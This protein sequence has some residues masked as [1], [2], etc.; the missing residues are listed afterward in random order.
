MTFRLPRAALKKGGLL[1]ALGPDGELRLPAEI[2][3]LDAQDVE[4]LRMRRAYTERMPISSRLPITYQIVPPWLRSVIA[5]AVGRWMRRSVGR[6]AAFPMWPI[7]LSADFLEDLAGCSPSPF[8][9][10][11]TPVVLTHDLDSPEGLRN[12][13]SHFLAEEEEVGARSASFVVPNGW[14]LEH[15]L[16]DEV[17][18]RGHEIG[19]H[20]YDHSNLTPYLSPEARRSRLR[21]AL[22]LIERYGVLGYRAPS[23]VRTRELLRDLGAYYRYDTSIPTSG[24]LFPVPNNGCASARLFRAEGIVEIPV[25][26]PRDGSL[27]FLGH[28]PE[29]IYCT[30]VHC[31]EQISR[32]GGVVV[33]L[34]HCEERFSGNP[35]MLDVYRRLL[36]YLAESGRFTWSTP[37]HVM[38]AFLQS[39]PTTPRECAA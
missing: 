38:D 32:S 10:G 9:A 23:L 33:L 3:Q 28:T 13:V 30:W 15:D 24:G 17:A 39:E 2:Q 34:T 16:L 8:A 5:S 14:P 27:R 25:S 7:D 18:A 12:V 31:A 19:I 26:M 6:W 35:A 4:P 1:G 29:E 11:P 22:P 36:L 21:A 20:G 37:R